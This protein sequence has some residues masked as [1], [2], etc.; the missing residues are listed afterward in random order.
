MGV[1]FRVEETCPRTASKRMVD[2]L[3]AVL[4][5]DERVFFAYLYGSSSHGLTGN[6]IDIAVYSRAG[7]DPHVLSADLKIEL[8]RKTG[9]CPDCFDIRVLNDMDAHCDIFGLLYLRNVLEGGRLLIDKRPDL[10]SDSATAWFIGIG[11]LTTGG[12]CIIPWRGVTTSIDVSRKLKHTRLREDSRF[13][14][15]HRS[16]G[17]R[18]ADT[19]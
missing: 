9:L 6:D 2:A 17:Q 12:S 16:D 14:G 5:Q 18:H 4:S 11:A 8:H 10:R 13:G 1:G 7:E 19:D 3:V 15:V